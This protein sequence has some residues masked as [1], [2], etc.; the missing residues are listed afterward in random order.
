LGSANKLLPFDI[1]YIYE[2]FFNV[3]RKLH[4]KVGVVVHKRSHLGN[5]WTDIQAVTTTA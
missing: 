5:K 2:H 3:F 4:A 1:L